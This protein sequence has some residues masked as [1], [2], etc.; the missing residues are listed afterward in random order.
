MPE[1]TDD[2]VL[3][4]NGNSGGDD[5]TVSTDYA[6]INGTNGHVQYMKLVDGTNG[7]TTVIPG[8]S[9]GLFIVP[10]Q[11]VQVITVASGGLTTATTAYTSGDQVGT[12]FT[13]A[14][15]ARASG[16]TGSILGVSLTDANDI[17]GSYDV[18]FFRASA[19]LAADNAAFSISDT[20]AKNIVEVVSLNYA[21]DLG[22]NRFARLMGLNVPYDCSGSTSLFA[23]LITRSAHT[24]FAAVTDLQ[25]TVYVARD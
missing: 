5:Y 23:A 22:A 10:R 9:Q 14:N 7:G 12:L 6:T 13:L 15:A 2:N 3:V 17:I 20:D 18:V 11:D 8:S 16:G 1:D 24:F 25:L 19:T 21:V 4:K